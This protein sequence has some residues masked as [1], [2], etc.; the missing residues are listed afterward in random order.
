MMEAG[1][2][3]GERDGNAALTV[4]TPDGRVLRSLVLSGERVTIGRLAGDNTV[5]L[6]PDPERLITR[7]GHCTLERHGDSWYIADGRSSNGTFL[8]RDGALM[9]IHEAV[10]LRDRDQICILAAVS[11]AGARRY[12]ELDFRATSDSETTRA[13]L[14]DEPPAQGCLRYDTTAGRLVLLHGGAETAIPIRPQAH[15]LV[16]YMVSRNAAA[17]A[18]VLCTHE[19][20]VGAVWS[21]EPLHS[22]LELAK[23]VWELRR[24]LAPYGADGLIEGERGLGYRLKSCVSG[25]A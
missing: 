6:S 19:E 22:R 10:E 20:L 3:A 15:R 13:V 5:A 8:R 12:F 16:R 17:G 11:P 2:A 21:G 23:L 18:A 14:V 25:H 7:V 9:R 24:K 4:F 1:P